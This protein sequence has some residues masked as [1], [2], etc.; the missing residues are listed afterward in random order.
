MKQRKRS[1]NP[2]RLQFFAVHGKH[3]DALRLHQFR[4]I[5]CGYVHPVVQFIR[6]LHILREQGKEITDFNAVVHSHF[7]P[8]P[9]QSQPDS[10]NTESDSQKDQDSDGDQNQE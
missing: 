3:A 4:H 10:Q 5:P 7:Q 1:G 8:P 6:T 9:D 2:D